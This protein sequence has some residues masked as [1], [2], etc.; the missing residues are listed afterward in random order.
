MC[1]CL[2]SSFSLLTLLFVEDDCE[3]SDQR[4]S[5][6]VVILNFFFHL[7]KIDLLDG[8]DTPLVLVDLELVAYLPKFYVWS[9]SDLCNANTRVLSYLH[10]KLFLSLVETGDFVDRFLNLVIQDLR[11][12]IEVSCQRYVIYAF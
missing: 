8:V 5:L 7:R 1:G 6:S 2:D 12:H 4:E 11:L 10:S 3:V 9:G